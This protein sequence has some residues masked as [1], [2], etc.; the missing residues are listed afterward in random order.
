MKLTLFTPASELHYFTI[1]LVSARATVCTLASLGL[2]SF[3]TRSYAS[4]LAS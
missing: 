3:C 2:L 1:L 4:M